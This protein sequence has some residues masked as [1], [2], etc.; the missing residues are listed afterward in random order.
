MELRPLQEDDLV[1]R[2]LGD[3]A[4]RAEPQDEA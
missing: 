4:R 2:W 3:E 1:A